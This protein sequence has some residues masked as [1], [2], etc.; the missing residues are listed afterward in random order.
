MDRL[1]TIRS[2]GI[3]VP[4]DCGTSWV[5]YKPR[6]IAGIVLVGMGTMN[7]PRRTKDEQ[8]QNLPHLMS[9]ANHRGRPSSRRR[10]EEQEMHGEANIRRSHLDGELESSRPCNNRSVSQTNRIYR[11][12][13]K[14]YGP[15]SSADRNTCRTPAVHS[16]LPYR[17]FDAARPYWSF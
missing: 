9:L 3:R 2:T 17:P 6:G 16:S 5:I 15:T 7:I 11:I 1:G 13:R 10:K 4:F 8:A 14:R 12:Y